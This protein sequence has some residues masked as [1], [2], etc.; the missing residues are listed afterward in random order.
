MPPA[1]RRIT[2]IN[3]SSFSFDGRVE[4][5][6]LRDTHDR[7]GRS[8]GGSA[9][10]AIPGSCYA[11]QST[12]DYERFNLDVVD[13]HT[14]RDRADKLDRELSGATTT[15]GSIRRQIVRPT[16]TPPRN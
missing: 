1:I 13:T 4:P 3:R 12:A 10:T 14:A 9:G 16:R 15:V 11:K 6:E 2:F 5:S 7:G 8:L